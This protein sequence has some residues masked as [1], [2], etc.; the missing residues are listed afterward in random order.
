MKAL[1]ASA[2]IRTASALSS[3]DTGTRSV[4]VR[5]CIS[6]DGTDDG[7]VEAVKAGEDVF[8]D[9]SDM[10][11]SSN[12]FPSPQ[13]DLNDR[14]QNPQVHSHAHKSFLGLYA[15]ALILGT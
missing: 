9:D 13:L 1:F 6:G 7:G 15:Q 14:N 4:R 10:V 2:F 5:F 3:S 11:A 8:E 12:V